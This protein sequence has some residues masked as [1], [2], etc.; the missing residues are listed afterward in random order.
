MRAALLVLADAGRPAE[1]D[2]ADHTPP[3]CGCIRARRCSFGL[4][5]LMTR[6]MGAVLGLRRKGAG[7][8][9]AKEV[10]MFMRAFRLIRTYA[11]V[12]EVWTQHDERKTSGNKDKT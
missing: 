11:V 4:F 6:E 2:T 1:P 5:V 12:E 9:I 7:T 3:G 8:C 10:S